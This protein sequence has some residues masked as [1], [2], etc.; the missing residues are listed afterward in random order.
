MKIGLLTNFLVK[1][2]MKDIF[3]VAD[4][5]Y[6]NGFEDLETGP[7][8]P[9]NYDKY[10]KIIQSEKIK[11][12]SLTYCRNYLSTDEAEA[13]LH[14]EELKKRIIFAS[15]LGIE[16]IVTSTG[17]DK[18]VEEGVYDRA[19]AIRKIPERSLDKFTLVFEP[20][21]KLAEEKKVKIAFENCPLMGNIAISPVM[22]RKIFQ[23]ID[24][25]NVGLAYDPS[26]LV[27][28]FIDPYEPIKEFK[29]RIF[30]VHAKDTQ[31]HRDLLKEGGFLTDFSWF[32]YR[33][34]GRGEI[35][36]SRFLS[37]LEQIGYTNTISIEHE[38]ADYEQNLDAVKEGLIMGKQYLKKFI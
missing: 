19:D 32:N 2:G 8:L 12:S 3:E 31:I 20:I 36:W 4:W 5:A 15:E 14:I 7:T 38:D 37:E 26:H 13:N 17:I 28:Q 22:W 25:P 18:S 29:N 23:R 9:L 24:S 10:L 6:E 11:I 27:W 21:I 1:E 33:I 35:D 30:H 34:P 16:K